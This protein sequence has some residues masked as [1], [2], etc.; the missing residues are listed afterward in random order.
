M[1]LTLFFTE[2]VALHTWHQNGMLARE[3][4]LYKKLKSQGVSVRFVTYGN[5]S[6]HRLSKELNGIELFTNDF[7]LP[8]EWYQRKLEW[9]PPAGDVFKSNQVAGADIA[10]AAARR[11]KAKFVARCGYLLSEF[12]ERKYGEASAEA[13]AA[14]ELEKR[15]FGEADKAVVTTQAMAD[16]VGEKYGV[17]AKSIQVIPNYVETD[18]FRPNE[19]KR[20]TSFRVGFVGRLDVQKNVF[21]LL[22]AVR[23]LDLELH[24]AG[25]GPQR[26]QLEEKAQ[27]A[28]AKVFFHGSIPNADLPGFLASCDMFVLPSLY[29]GHP[30]ALIEAMA[31]GLAVVGTRVPGVEN[32]LLDGETGLLCEPDVEGLREAISKLMS[33]AALRQKLGRAAREFVERNFSLDRVLELETK[34]LSSLNA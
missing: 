11:R 7:N 3:L 27:G 10:L 6:D 12:Q 34:M 17:D 21:A 33:D 20:P 24:L 23:D 31:T 29:E 13:L 28:K 8:L 2:G 26:A 15:V 9:W 14:R 32:L 25:Y 19:E 1:N 4:A 16:Y 22:D 5:R 30:K 18:R